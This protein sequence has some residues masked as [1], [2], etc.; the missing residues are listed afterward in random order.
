VLEHVGD[1]GKLVGA[2]EPG[3]DRLK[4]GQQLVQLVPQRRG[5]AGL[6]S[7]HDRV[8]PVPRRAPLV[9][10]DHPGRRGGQR[11]AAVQLEVEQLDQALRERC[12][13]TY[14]A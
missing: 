8:Q 11:V 14:F 12:D 1:H 5:G 7:D 10:L 4:L 9:V 13:H 2:A 6:V 3:R